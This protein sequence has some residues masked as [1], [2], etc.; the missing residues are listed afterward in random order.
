MPKR[1]SVS[2]S[3]SRV[4]SV[5]RASRVRSGSKRRKINPL[6]WLIIRSSQ[7]T[8]KVNRLFSMIETKEITH[9]IAGTSMAH[10]ALSL[11]NDADSGIRYNPFRLSQGTADTD[12]HQN[13]GGNRVGDAIT[14]K[15]MKLK[16]MFENSLERTK[17][18]YRCMLL[19]CARGDAPTR[20]TLFKDRTNNKMLDAIDSKRYS[21][22]WQK[23]FTCVPGNNSANSYATLTGVPTG[24]TA[25]ALPGNK[26]ISAWIPGRKFGRNGNVQYEQGSTTNVKFYDYHF[27]VLV[28]DWNGTP[29]DLNNVGYL[30]EFYSTVYFKDA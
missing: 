12:A 21:V 27:C 6:P 4:R 16:M 1:K 23:T 24:Q 3:R 14:V 7:N 22:V 17:V 13:I 18:Y 15:G 29:Q 28:Y 11:F 26:I 25:A 5:A 20:T 10:N 30:N 8:Q 19:K 2:S 9:R